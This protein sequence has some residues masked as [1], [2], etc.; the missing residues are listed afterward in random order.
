M[1]D[2]PVTQFFLKRNNVLILE[3]EGGCAEGGRDCPTW[4]VSH[5]SVGLTTP[6]PGQPLG[7]T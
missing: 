7:A 6:P 5:H 4:L 3:A 2:R 1:S